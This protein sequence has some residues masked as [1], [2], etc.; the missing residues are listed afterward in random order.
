[1]I[2]IADSGSTKT[3]WALIDDP[4]LIIRQTTKGFNP[5]YFPAPVLESSIN[6]LI[7]GVPPEEVTHLYFYGSGCSSEL[8]RKLV[9][10]VFKKHFPKAIVEV[11]HDLFGAARALFGNHKGIASI[12][13]TGSSSCLFQHNT[14]TFAIPSLGYLLADE[15]SGTHLGRLLL[16]A[17]FKNELSASISKKLEAEYEIDPKTFIT[18]LYAREKPNAFI[19][20]FT[21]FLISH[22][23]DDI[24]RKLIKEAFRTFFKEIILKYPE[25][26]SHALGFSGS[27]AYLLNDHLSEVA[28]E[29]GLDINEV[30][31]DPVENL[32]AYHLNDKVF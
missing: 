28:A 29:F 32:I 27:V 8:S 14:I 23:H 19:A 31:R 18:T 10:D 22:Q 16:N 6:N 4:Q 17:Y 26:G 3:E 2:I 20:S 5:V 13:G 12:L 25:Y 11:N 21:P 24:I 15:G 1:M 9:G 7:L 30:I